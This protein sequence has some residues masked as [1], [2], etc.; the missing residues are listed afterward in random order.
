MSDEVRETQ[1][2]FGRILSAVG[3]IWIV[4]FVVANFFDVGGTPLGDILRFF[5]DSFFV[6]I[7]LLFAGRAIRRRSGEMPQR[8]TMAEQRQPQ[9]QAAQ[10]RPAA[11]PAPRP[12]R[13]PISTTEGKVATP[14]ESKT[15]PMP[16]PAEPDIEELAVAIGFDDKTAAEPPSERPGSANKDQF[17]PRYEPT[18]KSK[19]SEEMIN[20]ARK[21]LKKKS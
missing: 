6:P 20:E 14:T 16:T 15:K 5:G 11:K 21:R 12:E 4:L 13:K 18:Y 10:R 8:T 3:S 7:A 9:R 1:A 2:R 17:K 19:S